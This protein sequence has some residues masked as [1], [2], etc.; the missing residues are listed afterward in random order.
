[1]RLNNKMAVIRAALCAWLFTG[2]AFTQAA[3]VDGPFFDWYETGLVRYPYEPQFTTLYGFGLGSDIAYFVQRSYNVWG[4]VNDNG[5]KVF[6]SDWGVSLTGSVYPP[7]GTDEVWWTFRVYGPDSA[8]VETQTLVWYLNVNGQHSAQ[9]GGL[10]Y[11]FV[12]TKYPFPLRGIWAVHE[13]AFITHC[14]PPGNYYITVNNGTPYPFELAA[15]PAKAK[16][17]ALGPDPQQ[18]SIWTSGIKNSSTQDYEVTVEDECGNIIPNADVTLDYSPVPNSGG[19]DHDGPNRPSG[20]FDLNAT[21][22]TSEPPAPA[23]PFNV[24]TG[25]SGRV[26][27]KYTAPQVSGQIKVTTNCT[28]ATGAACDPNEQKINV[29][30]SPR[31]VPLGAGGYYDLIGSYGMPNVSSMHVDNHWV[32]SSFATKLKRLAESYFVKYTDK[33]AYNDMSLEDGGLFDIFNNWKP[34]HHEHRI[35]ISADV[36]LVPVERRQELLKMIPNAGIVGATGFEEPKN[37][38][39]LR[40]YGGNQ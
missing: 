26:T 5:G 29:A 34:D 2:S 8:V 20:K 18:P 28:L 16:L 39:H 14:R 6:R 25:R 31:L 36:R 11:C 13:F 12:S 27:V 4:L 30:V 9:C 32:T 33:L 38:W 1:M 40:E 19:H 21:T 37:H 17:R 15:A 23:T 24:S 22:Y 35:G 3:A 10:E 7:A